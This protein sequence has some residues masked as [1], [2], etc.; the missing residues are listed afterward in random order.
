MRDQPLQLDDHLGRA[1]AREL[2]VDPLH[3]RQQV[4]L[5]Q[6]P[7]LRLELADGGEVRERRAAPQA[8]R[9]AQ[10]CRRPR[11]VA[12]SQQCAALVDQPLEGRRV[13]LVGLELEQ[14]PAAAR[15][16][17]LGALVAERPAQPGH[18]HVNGVG[19]AARPRAP[20]SCSI[21]RS[22]LTISF[23]CTSRTREQR[24]LA[25]AAQRQRSRHPGQPSAARGSGTAP[26]SS[27]ASASR[28]YRTSG[29]RR[30][31]GS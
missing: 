8:E 12:A 28:D 17:H 31:I 19:R 15:E 18:G 27:P 22:V 29:R 4:Q 3:L 9:L 30:A 1:T 21:S 2:G 7:D 14:V 11:R 6:A 25:L 10:P 5:L 16:E 13:E 23:A 20:N 26:R 24:A